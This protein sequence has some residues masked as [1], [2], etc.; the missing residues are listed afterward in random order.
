MKRNDDKD[1]VSPMEEELMRSLSQTAKEHEK[2]DFDELYAR[3]EAGEATNVKKP[4]RRGLRP[5]VTAACVV[6]LLVAAVFGATR[7]QNSELS[8]SAGGDTS[9]NPESGEQPY[10][11]VWQALS[12]LGETY[13]ETFKLAG[14]MTE[15]ATKAEADTGAALQDAAPEA[16]AGTSEGGAD[17]GETNVQVAGV[18]EADILKNDGEYLYV[19]GYDG[20]GKRQLSVVHAES[21]TLRCQK[22]LDDTDS[23][24]YT[25]EMYVTGD[26]LILVGSRAKVLPGGEAEESS[27]VTPET[28]IIACGGLYMDDSTSYA[29]VF[30]LSEDRTGVTSLRYHEQSGAY[31]SSRMVDGTLY[32]VSS[33]YFAVTQPIAY[34]DVEEYLPF[35]RDSADADYTVLPA[36]CIDVTANPRD[37]YT[38]VSAVPV[39]GDGETVT[40][41]VMGSSGDIIYSS[42][43]DLYVMVYGEDGLQAMRFALG[44]GTVAEPVTGEVPGDMLNN[45]FSMDEYGGYFRVVTTKWTDDGQTNRLYVLDENMELVGESAELAPGE[46]VYSVRFMGDM[47]YVVTFLQVDPLFAIDLSDPENPEVKGQLK[48]PGFSTYMHPM[49]ADTLIGVGYDADEE[50]G[51][52]GGLKISLF[53]VSDPLDPKE[54]DKLVAKGEVDSSAAYDHKAFTYIADKNL[55]IMPVYVY[56]AAEL[57]G[58]TLSENLNGG[59]LVLQVTKEGVRLK[60]TMADLKENEEEYYSGRDI[61]RTTYIGNTLYTVSARSVM[62]VDLET[63]ALK[64]QLDLY[65]YK[66]PEEEESQEAVLPEEDIEPFVVYD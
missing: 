64:K 6:V 55:L 42:T 60:G 56:G 21:M 16:A 61:Q 23:Y 33:Q 17:Y 54:T 41:S 39:T 48:I 62:A 40:R 4:K 5:F 57:D 20:D 3:I 45:Q 59:A 36:G 38:Q 30:R 1:R 44:Q 8:V 34:D 18:D 11:D 46:T 51:R 31:S 26:T 2:R 66:E 9:Q 37:Q 50:T 32:L 12:G 53:D 52:R 10:Y 27:G 63:L 28:E 7:L 29:E 47:A 25:H 15:Q 49:D 19:L 14:A 43:N 58:K 24:Q 22:I 35:V 13:E 65:E